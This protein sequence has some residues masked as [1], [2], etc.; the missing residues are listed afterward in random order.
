MRLGMEIYKQNRKFMNGNVYSFPPPQP[1]PPPLRCA[2]WSPPPP[3]W[4]CSGASR[5]EGGHP[6]PTP[7]STIGEGSRAPNQSGNVSTF[8][9]TDNL[10]S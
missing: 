7:P 9:K 2:V 4:P 1:P 3:Q 10:E 6:S 5:T 8:A